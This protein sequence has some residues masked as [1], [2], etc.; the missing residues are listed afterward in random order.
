M[1]SENEVLNKKIHTV[2]EEVIQF[3]IHINLKLKSILEKYTRASEDAD[4]KSKVIQQY[5]LR[6]H[7]QKIQPEPKPGVI[8]YNPICLLLVV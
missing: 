2:D 4:K 1:A 6:E 8:L 5:V 3:K 7:A